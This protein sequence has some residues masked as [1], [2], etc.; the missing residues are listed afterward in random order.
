M[1]AVQQIGVIV[2]GPN[3]RASNIFQL[4]DPVGS[5]FEDDA[6]E[7]LRLR[8][9]P[10]HAQCDLKTLLWVGR[11]AASLVGS[12][13]TRMAYLRSPKMRTSPTPGIRFSASLT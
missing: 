13:Q 1:P 2:L 12:S 11:R 5:V 6:L 10:H 4:D 7:F 9:S 3:L 8:Q